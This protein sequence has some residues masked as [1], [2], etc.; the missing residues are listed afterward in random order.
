VLFRSWSVDDGLHWYG[1]GETAAGVPTGDQTISFKPIFGWEPPPNKLVTI[2]RE[3]ITTVS[4]AYRLLAGSLLVTI[5]PAN[6]RAAGAQ[7]R[8]N[9]GP[10]RNSGETAAGLPVGQYVISF[11]PVSGWARPGD[12]TVAAVDTQTTA[13]VRAYILQ[14]GSL[15]VTIEPVGA[16]IAG[17]QWRVD[18]GTW[19]DSEAIEIRLT[20]GPHT[21]EFSD[22]VGWS[23]P[24]EQTV[25]ISPDTTTTTSRTYRQQVGALRVMIGPADAQTAGAQWRLDGGPW[26][27]GGEELSG[28]PVG[29]HTVSFE[30]IVG[31][32]SPVDQVVTVA[33]GETAMV[34]AT[35]LRQLGALRVTLGPQ[36]ARTAPPPPGCSARSP[37]SR[38]PGA[39]RPPARP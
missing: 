1:S 3:V 16:R 17:A 13:L 37:S 9:D 14:T 31:W 34:S 10:W 33:T 18:G 24:G 29:P 21:V 35:Y 8:V 30:S 6:V 25:L 23:K 22:A 28:V 12:E 2:Q 32:T 27:A 20:I 4:D 38:A 7:W 36:A 26:H 39:P 5:E 19:H 15:Q 11:Q